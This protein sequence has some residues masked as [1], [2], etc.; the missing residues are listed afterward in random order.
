MTR[1]TYARINKRSSFY[2]RREDYPSGLW[3]QLDENYDDPEHRFYTDAWCEEER[4]RALVN[5]DLNMAH[6]ASL[7]P[8]VFDDALHRAVRKYRMVEVTDLSKWDGVHGLYIMVL[9]QYCQVYVGGAAG[10]G[11]VMKRVK[12]HWT[13]TQP[14]D[15]LIWP[16]VES[17]ILAIDSFR[18]LDTTRIFAL[19]TASPFELVA[20]LVESIPSSF[21]L[22]RILGGRDAVK[23]AAIVGVDKV[24]KRREFPA[25][26]AQTS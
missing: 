19:K 14:L 16:E 8:A 15:R 25:P 5:L 6:F 23:L 4:E 7:D 10:A 11:G 26:D 2:V 18:A 21:R 1:E 20:E 13:R 3:E 17:S 9:D 22:N 24:M 12:Q